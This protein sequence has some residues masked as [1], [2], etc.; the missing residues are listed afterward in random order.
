MSGNVNKIDLGNLNDQQNMLL[1]Q[2]SYESDIFKDKYNDMTLHTI[3]KN[4]NDTGVD[5]D[6]KAYKTV[7]AL[8]EANLGELCIREVA[9]DN[10]TGF[11]AVSFTD[12]YG[13]KGVS[14]RGTD[15]VPSRKSL[16]DWLDNIMALSAGTSVQTSQAEA[17][18]DDVKNSDGTN[19]IYGHSKGGQLSESVYVNNNEDIKGV[20]LLN[21][22]PLNPYSLTPSQF[23]AMNSDKIDIIIVEGDYVWFLGRLPSY[24]NIR[25]AKKIPGEDSH[26]YS[27]IDFESG[28]IKDGEMPWWEY[29]AYLVITSITDGIQFFGSGL[30]F[31]Y[32]CVVNTIEYIKEDLYQDAKEFV[33][34]VCDFL[35]KIDA[36]LRDFSQKLK[37]YLGEIV[38]KAN[39]WLKSKF[40]SSSANPIPQQIK[41]DTY[42]LKQYA[43]R[44]DSVNKRISKLDRRL[45][46]LYWRVG[47]LGLWNLIQADA[48]TGYSWRLKRCADYL[49]T[50]ANNFD[51]VEKR[52]NNSL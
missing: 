20:H 22:Q 23:Y 11:G 29:P 17:F 37:Q 24:F 38:S 9:H 18:F 31:V 21:P 42:K 12:S 44:I 43:Q 27:S 40:N 49:N 19:Y 13:N 28:K 4:M 46:G 7:K 26:L 8:I 5:T 52:L 41:L 45:D 10:T 30:G 25:I 33:A 51:S 15:G 35:E 1:T 48:L 32:N 2:L 34:S 6:S 50:T 3:F 16:N 39:N 36:K 47:L 14:Y